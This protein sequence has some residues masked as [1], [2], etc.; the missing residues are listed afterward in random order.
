MKLTVIG[1]GSIGSAV[2]DELIGWEDVEQVQ[3]CDARARS[4]QELHEQ[5]GDPKLRSFQVDVRDPSVLEPILQGSACVIGC[6]APEFN[7][8]LARLCLHL[9]T[10]FCDLGGNDELVRQELTLDPEAR[11]KGVWVVPN[12]GLA[13]GLVNILCL[14]GISQFDEVAAA[15]LRVGDVPLHP[16]PPFNFRISW[17]AEKLLD[18]YTHPVQLIE[19]GE[20][21]QHAPFSFEERIVFPAPFG[22][23]EAFCTAGGLSALAGQL[24]GRVRRLDHK[25]IRWPGHADQMQFLLGLGFGEARSIDVRTHLTYRDVLVRRMRQRL[26]GAY[27]DAVLM[28]V[29]IQGLRDG[30]PQTLLFEMV[31]RYEPTRG[32]TAMRRCTSLSTAVVAYLIAAGAVPGGGAAPPENVVP[33]DRFCGLVADRG[34]PITTTWHDGY[35]DVTCPAGP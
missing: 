6:A 25:T 24:A 17:S 16:E 14:Y 8:D 35:V 13:P 29:L 1:A 23:M 34:L 9:G 4:L 31:D 7:P 19:D 12:C 22:E 27:E 26:G 30:R 3:V 28:R 2:A 20:V 5:R 11:S 18:D 32:M 15:H 10:H 21:R 33:H